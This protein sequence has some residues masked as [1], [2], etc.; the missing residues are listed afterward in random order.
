MSRMG[1]FIANAFRTSPKNIP[2]DSTAAVISNAAGWTAVDKG[3]VGKPRARQYRH[4]AEHSEWVRAAI[5]VRKSQVSQS[6]WEIVKF[7]QNGPDPSPALMAK[8]KDLFHH[9]SPT[10][11]STS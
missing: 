1:E 11:N 5:D 9:P 7:D 8:V 10:I 6:E 2:A 4:W 3:R